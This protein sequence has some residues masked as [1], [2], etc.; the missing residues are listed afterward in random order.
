MAHS[1]RAVEPRGAAT[2]ASLRSVALVVALTLCMIAGSCAS[3]SGSPAPGLSE[4][5]W[6]TDAPS[7]SAANH[8]PARWELFDTVASLEVLATFPSHGH[9]TGA[10]DAELRANV[11][12]KASFDSLLPG[13]HF[14]AGALLVQSHS[15]RHSG[16]QLGSFAML[17]RDKGY[18][19]TGGDWEFLVI[20]RD[21]IIA[22]SGKLEACARCHADAAADYVFPRYQ[23]SVASST[24]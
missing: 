16:A 19:P 20:E 2:A 10:W 8:R 9:G 23:P 11:P 4:P 21:G 12:A 24:D 18:F 7:S 6:P 22:A 3:R 5:P 15:Q 1:K 17:K 13:D 14:P